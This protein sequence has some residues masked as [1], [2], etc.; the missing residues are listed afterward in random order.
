MEVINDASVSVN[1]RIAQVRAVLNISQVKFSRVIYLSS[2][3]L[4]GIEV[5]KRR[6][7]DRVIKLICASFG[8]SEKW[9]RDGEGEMF[10]HNHEN[11]YATLIALYKE[12]T[13]AYQQYIL[14]QI[15][16]LLNIQDVDNSKKQ[17][18]SNQYVQNIM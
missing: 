1:R 10:D 8:V 6:V 15:N 3:Y 16:L 14:K 12:L 11:K 2:G 4:A 17:T 5:D 18:Q 13:P 7:N 9:L